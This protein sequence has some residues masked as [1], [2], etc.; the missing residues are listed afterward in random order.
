MLQMG[1]D[2][3]RYGA[4][5]ADF[6]PRIIDS[7]E[8]HERLLGLA[9]SIMEKGEELSEEEEKLL[10]LIVLLVEAYEVNVSEAED[11]DDDPDNP[12]AAHITLQRLMFSHDIKL[13]DIAHFFGNP[14]LAREVLD[15]K[16]Q[17]SKRQAKE[18]AKFFR[19]PA[20]LFAP[21]V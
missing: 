17:I 1:M 6:R 4:L 15:G 10:A 8:E 2:E 14:H 12:P 19:V 11:E 13:D 9:E 21:D 16:R 5:L 20:K 3:Q 18:L 7:P